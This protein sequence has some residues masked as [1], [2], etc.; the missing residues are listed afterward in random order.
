MLAVRDQENLVHSRQTAA[1]SK[2]LNQGAKHV[3]PKTPGARAPKTPFKIPL[4]DE[5]ATGRGGGKSVM[6]PVNKTNENS[7]TSG[8]AGGGTSFVTPLGPR[9]RAPLGMKTTNAKA[10]AFQTPLAQGGDDRFEKTQADEKIQ[11]QSATARRIKPISSQTD[12]SKL[13]V[14]GVKV[15]KDE[16]REIEYMPP[17]PK[18]LPDYPEDFP[19][20]MDYSQLQ[21]ENLTRGWFQ[22][23]YNPIDDDGISLAERQWEEQRKKADKQMDELMQRVIEDMPLIGYN[24]PE[25]PGDETFVSAR[26]KREA[27]E[28]RRKEVAATTLKPTLARKPAMTTRGP[29]MAT[30]K[31]AAKA[32]SIKPESAKMATIRPKPAPKA[33]IPT[34]FLVRSK[35][36]NAPKPTNPSSMRHTAAIT[37]SKTTLGYTNGRSA[38]ATLSQK[39]PASNNKNTNTKRSPFTGSSS[40]TLTPAMFAARTKPEFGTEEWRRMKAYSGFDSDDEVAQSLRGEGWDVDEEAEEDFEL[41]W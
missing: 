22:H 3:A 24:V 18:E 8:T 17:K 6:K 29:S 23:Y 1:A 10:K 27:E 31:K 38:S 25:F 15:S 12:G 37:T 30:S 19:P 13:E 5:N 36:D 4:N 35:N 26:S 41:K 2:P 32:L 28:Q 20:D 34:A 40:S 7:V 11:Q 33:R 16:E 21:G 14:R 9:N 39:A